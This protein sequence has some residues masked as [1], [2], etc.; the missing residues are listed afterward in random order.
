I[1]GVPRQLINTFKG[2]DTS[3]GQLTPEP[4]G[5]FLGDLEQTIYGTSKP[6]SFQS[7]GE[8]LPFVKEGS[9]F[10]PFLGAAASI[11]DLTGAGSAG[12]KLVLALKATDDAI[13][14]TRLMKA[15]GFADE[16]AKDYGP[17]LAKITDAGKIEK[18]YEEANTRYKTIKERSFIGSTKEIA[19]DLSKR[20]AGQYIPRDTD[21][22]A[23]RAKNLVSDN[24][25]AAETLARTGSSDKAVATAAELI[26]HYTETARTAA[27]AATKNTLFDKAADIAHTTARTLTEYTRAV[28]A[29]S[30]LGRLTPE[31]I[32]RFAAREIQKYNEAIDVAKSKLGGINPTAMKSKIPELTGEQVADFTK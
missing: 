31:G 15:A 29:A 12:K 10:A 8:G 2:G 25:D 17:A 32:V 6:I 26:K 5:T 14:A 9:S 11:L 22:L 3:S 28:Q 4:R 21:E 16:I 20:I 18:T 30:I 7:E 24:I 19:P 1:A 23:I 27:D 13:E